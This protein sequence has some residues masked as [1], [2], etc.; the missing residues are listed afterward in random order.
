MTKNILSTYINNY[1]NPILIYDLE[2]INK[3]MKFLTDICQDSPIKIL[4]TVKSFPYRE[5]IDLAYKL[6]PGFEISNLNEY[7]LLPKGL[8]DIIL[9]ISD[10][11]GQLN[12]NVP[13]ELFQKNTC[14]LNFDEINENQILSFNFKPEINYGA[15]VSHTSLID[16]SKSEVK[17]SRFGNSIHKLVQLKNTIFTK[18][19][20]GLHLHNGSE[21]NTLDDYLMMADKI[22]YT[23]KKENIKIS[24]LN[25]GGGLHRLT[26]KELEELIQKLTPSFMD[27]NL[28][29]FFEPGNC[30]VR[31][32][33][34]ALG[35]I[36]SI[37]QFSQ[38]KYHLVLDLSNEC[39]LKWAEP[40]LL[41]KE[42]LQALDSK[43]GLTVF[44]GGPNCFEHDCLGIIKVD[45][46]DGKLPFKLNEILAFGNINGYAAAW[47]TSFNGINKA[48]I[49]FC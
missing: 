41:N 37:K 25:L 35:K 36:L 39:H 21:E 19:I 48:T 11:T 14:Y 40:I 34:Y 7:N 32:A 6:M 9:S 49:A 4:F 31:H 45:P 1:Q 12:T 2:Q 30:I 5:I 46:I 29:G 33:G 17:E 18:K 44:I 10:P 23:L 42:T 47:N 20:K 38:E 43:Q 26:D 28:H 8:K 15:R 3:K 22:F 13:I 16:C 27:H 24:F